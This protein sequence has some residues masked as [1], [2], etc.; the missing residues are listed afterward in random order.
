MLVLCAVCS[1]LLAPLDAGASGPQGPLRGPRNCTSTPPG[2]GGPPPPY[3]AGVIVVS[4]PDIIVFSDEG[5][6]MYVQ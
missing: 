2:R 4:P 1:T 3:I 5:H 6:L